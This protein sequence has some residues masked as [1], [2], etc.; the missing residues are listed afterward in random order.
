MVVVCPAQ[1]T[2]DP[3]WPEG[4]LPL[5][6]QDIEA[7]AETREEYFIPACARI[8]YGH[9][10]QPR[11]WHQIISSDIGNST[12]FGLEIL[13]HGRS[14][15]R[16]FAILHLQVHGNNILDI[17]RA[18]AGRRNTTGLQTEIASAFP[19][20]VSLAP[21]RRP[22][23]I[24]FM[25]SPEEL[26]PPPGAALVESWSN[27]E[28]WLWQLASRTNRADFPPDPDR[29]FELLAGTVPLSADWR[30]LVARDGAAF[31]AR[32]YDLGDADPFLGFA[33]LYTHSIY[34]DALIIGMLQNT[35][36][37]EMIDDASRAFEANDLPRHLARLE[38]RAARFRAVFWLRDV[39]TH[40]PANEILAA[41]QGQHRLPERFEAV[42]SEIADLNRIVQTQE[43]QR[44]NAALGIITVVGLP[45]GIAF[46][47]MQVLGVSSTS[48]LLVGMAAAASCTGALLLTGFGRLLLRT[49]R[50]LKRE[51]V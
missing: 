36:I 50:R 20:W 37:S 41:Y 11:R 12:A 31:V 39:G 26:G 19:S 9:P 49:L 47:V 25:S 15:S 30:G 17:A 3:D 44:V 16:A 45:F 51:E 8:L 14:A 35:T 24:C 2:G 10:S 34:L 5:R 21:L 13:T 32:R 42:L 40:G 4:P 27:L 6:Q 48:A 22:F 29:A 46:A 28:T 43:S 18:V 1:I 7:T 38:G 23:T 33:Q